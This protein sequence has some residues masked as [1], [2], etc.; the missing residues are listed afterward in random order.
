VP[1]TG[2]NV[3]FG[4][5]ERVRA[6]DFAAKLS[7][8]VLSR[9]WQMLLKGIAE[10]QG[11][12]RPAAAAE[13]VLVRIAYVAD[14]PTPDEALRMLEQNDGGSTPA[15]GS[16][17][18]A[19][20][21]SAGSSSAGASTPMAP[22]PVRTASPAAPRAQLEPLTR[23]QMAAP[24]PA[25]QAAPH[26][27]LDTFPEL[28]ALAAAKRDLQV[29][30]ALEADVRLVRM[31]DGRLEVAMERSASRGL[32][33]DLSRKLEQWTGRRWTVIV[34]NEEG[35]PTLRSQAQVLQSQ[36]ER[37]AEADP[38]VREVMARFPGAKIVEVRRLAP[39]VSEADAAG[40]I[41][42]EPFDG[43]DD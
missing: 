26:V 29:K 33:S 13:M 18:T 17:T 23:P 21:S 43:D 20:S 34:S 14:L 38:R 22:M 7:M 36:R 24:A 30:A 39:E 32:I 28:V 6:R 9:M 12:T 4:E 11:A 16:A 2:D 15:R 19:G 1:A 8:R 10:V 5:T 25:E 42:E 3:V 31:E 35:Q 27:R 40:D 37:S 41:V